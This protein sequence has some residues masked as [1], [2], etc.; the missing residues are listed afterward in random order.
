MESSQP[1]LCAYMTKLEEKINNK[2]DDPSSSTEPTPLPETSEN[3]ATPPP[4]PLDDDEEEQ[5][6]DEEDEDEEEELDAADDEKEIAEKSNSETEETNDQQEA[7][8]NMEKPECNEGEK[9]AEDEGEDISKQEKN[10]ESI[11]LSNTVTNHDDM[12]DIEESIPTAILVQ[13]KDTETEESKVIEMNKE[14]GVNVPEM[15]AQMDDMHNKSEVIDE[16]EKIPAQE[17]DFGG[18]IKSEDM[19]EENLAIDPKKDDVKDEPM[20]TDEK[21]EIVIIKSESNSVVDATEMKE[22]IEM[23]PL[24]EKWFS[25]VNRE[26]P[27][28]T[29]D[30]IVMYGSQ[31]ANCNMTCRDPFQFQG[32]KWDISNNI[33]HFNIPFENRNDVHFLHESALSLSGLDDNVIDKVVRGLNVDKCIIKD[34]PT[35]EDD[36]ILQKDMEMGMDDIKSSDVKTDEIGN[37]NFTL[38]PYINLSLNNLTAYIQCDVGTPLQMTLEEQKQLEEIKVILLKMI[39]FS[40]L[41]FTKYVQ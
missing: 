36:D 8:I 25:I 28:T 18:G 38:P 34:E 16:K 30:C 1:D 5:V 6:E 29:P 13:Q 2:E 3:P 40:F 9:M 7:D 19:I 22:D 35:F 39:Y 4:L 41:L 27:L 12:L 37:H 21:P 31:I 10:T 26:M 11:D 20:D 23:K 24:M 15:V 17:I 14:V 32:H 33:Q